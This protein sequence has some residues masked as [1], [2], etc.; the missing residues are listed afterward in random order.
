M[1]EPSTATERVA[2]LTD[3]A[4]RDPEGCR[5]A[6][7]AELLAQRARVGQ[8]GLADA[9]LAV[10]VAAHERHEPGAAMVA[11][12][13]AELAATDERVRLAVELVKLEV[14]TVLGNSLASIETGRAALGRARALADVEAEGT[15]LI[16]LGFVYAQRDEPAAYA[17]YS[18]QALAHF[19]RIGHAQGEAHALCNLG[20]ALSSLHEMDEAM[21]CYA[22]C[23]P[24]ALSL[25]WRRGVALALAG[26]GGVHLARGDVERGLRCYRESRV[27]LEELG[28]RFQI[29]RHGQL[30]GQYLL[31]LGRPAL[32]LEA[33][34]EAVE[35]AR[36]QGF[37]GLAA[38]VHLARSRALEAVGELPGAL[39][40][41][42]SHLACHD[43]EARQQV[44][45]RI[46]A[47]EVE[48]RVQGAR[49]EA[50]HE[51]G[52][53]AELTR[54]NEALRAALYRQQELQDELRRL[55]ETDTLTGLSNRRKL[56]EFAEQ[57]IRRGLRS[58]RGFAL[59]LLDVDH[60][61]AVNDRHG[62]AVGDEVLVELGG[63]LVAAI[64]CVDVASRWGGEE[65]CVL[66][67]ETD[68][69]G[70]EVA[71]E[72]VR[73]AVEEAPF[74]TSAGPL[75]IT[76]SGGLAEWSR[77]RHAGVL[78]E[79]L[80]RADR[81]LYSAKRAGRNRVVKAK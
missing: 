34:D 61:K 26:Q 29:A 28:E 42:R 50:E 17:D 31:E 74:L 20:G 66:L 30:V 25:G 4:R 37:L 73:A 35:I 5:V 14:T 11:L 2:Q 48:Q 38:A 56:R 12:V 24:M 79:V 1:P 67:V 76:L 49:K 46:R 52:R 45:D 80:S 41:L 8:P 18:R 68:A 81:A 21:G 3:A 78:D 36:D 47:I 64:R 9:A 58:G 69:A 70:A 77:D 72:R 59:L 55:A 75:S 57:E 32:A 19:Q 16:N 33:L 40:A 15:I 7:E 60:F 54:T 39:E 71:A 53:V 63:R 6:W 10:A 44:E 43:G 65:F 51:R 13:E 62:H 27:I 23:L 22:A